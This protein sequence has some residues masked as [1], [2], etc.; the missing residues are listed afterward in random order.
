MEGPLVSVVSRSSCLAE[1]SI[2]R[3][4]RKS[5]TV[6]RSWTY[7]IYDT[8]ESIEA[9]RVLGKVFKR[10]KFQATV[11]GEDRDRRWHKQEI[12]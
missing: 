5:R 4:R 12:H 10:K 9:L 8:L 6:S 11:A 3:V 2:Q 1:G 7:I